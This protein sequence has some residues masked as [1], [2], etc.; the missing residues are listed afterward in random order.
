[1]SGKLWKNSKEQNSNI[2]RLAVIA[3]LLW[4]SS[5][6]VKE[7]FPVIVRLYASWNRYFLITVAVYIFIRIAC[8]EIRKDWRG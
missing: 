4:M 1:M 6:P 7:N 3:L 8:I 5:L 2:G